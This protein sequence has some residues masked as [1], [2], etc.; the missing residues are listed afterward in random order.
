MII[1]D[2]RFASAV[3]ATDE[4]GG[5]TPLLFDDVG[6]QIRYEASRPELEILA[7][8]VHDHGTNRWLRA[9]TAHYVRSPRLH[10]PMASGIAAF[11]DESV[12]AKLATELEAEVIG[13]EAV[14]R[15]E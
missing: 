7:R 14:W 6:D 13:F 2:E 9:E 1:N 5:A 10:T 8:W 3:I 12:A 15:L 11:E 4:R